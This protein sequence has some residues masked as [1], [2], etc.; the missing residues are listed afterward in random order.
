MPEMY[1]CSLKWKQGHS[2]LGIRGLQARIICVEVFPG[3]PRL[4]PEN[5]K[6]F[7]EVSATFT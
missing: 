2:Y 4:T 1:K 5:A 3:N 6:I 7:L